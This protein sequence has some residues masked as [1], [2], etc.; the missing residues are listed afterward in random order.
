[1]SC[2]E[3]RW[4]PIVSGAS[5]DLWTRRRA[6]RWRGGTFQSRESQDP[7]GLETAARRVLAANQELRQQL[8]GYDAVIEYCLE[9]FRVGTRL[10]DLISAMP[11]IEAT[12]GSQ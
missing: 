5:S 2:S 3:G 9:Q 1:M 8:D 7:F 11:S 12:I 10:V 4:R 6:V